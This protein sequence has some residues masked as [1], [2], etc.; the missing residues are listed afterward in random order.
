MCAKIDRIVRIPRSLIVLDRG[1]HRFHQVVIAQ[2]LCAVANFRQNQNG[3]CL[4]SL[5]DQ[6]LA[7]VEDLALRIRN[8]VALRGRTRR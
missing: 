4:D 5:I 1:S 2:I 6:S 8:S 7:L 3:S